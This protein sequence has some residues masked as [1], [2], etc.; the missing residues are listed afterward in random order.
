MGKRDSEK[1]IMKGLL[2]F[3]A[4]LNFLGEILA[5]F[6]GDEVAVNDFFTA[7]MLFLILATV[8]KEY[9]EF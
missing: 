3:I 1:I 4:L 7:G 9:E 6:R 8:F 2:Y 5:K